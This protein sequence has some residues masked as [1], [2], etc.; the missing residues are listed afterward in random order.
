MKIT[1]Y[2]TV[3]VMLAG[4]YSQQAYAEKLVMLHTNDT[5]S[6][7]DPTDKNLGGVLRRKVLIDSVRAAQPNTLLID[8]GDAVQGT[9]FFNLYRGEVEHKVMNMLGYDIAI[10][11]NH[12][13][14]NGVDELAENLRHNHATWL[15]TNYDLDGSAL[16]GLFKPYTIKKFGDH[17]VG[18]IG[19]NLEPKG[20]ISEGNYDGVVY[21]DAIKAANATAWHLKHNEKADYVVAVTHIG[22]DSPVLPNDLELAAAS[23]DI[24]IIIGGHSHTVINPGSGA[25]LVTNAAGRPVL[26][27]QA[28]KSGA[29]MGEITL[30]LDDGETDYR[31]LSVDSR[32][33]SRT[34][35]ELDAILEPYRHGVDSLMNIKIGRSAGNYGNR[36]PELINFVSDFILDQGRRMTPDIDLAI[37][38]KGSLRRDMPKGDVTKGVIL[39]MQPFAN[40]IVTLEVKGSDL[41]E[42]FDVM[43]TRGGDGV[44]RGVDIAFD[45]ATGQCTD[46][47]I[48]GRPLDPDATY[49]VATIDY[50]A[51]GGDY[52]EPLT[53]GNRLSE[54]K[55]VVHDD[56]IDYIVSLKN[57]KINPSSTL[58]MHPAR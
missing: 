50:L 24:D 25:E 2:A 48:N 26:V 44:S 57:K 31:L 51:N 37:M 35:R 32:L 38:N 22:Y 52:M 55:G 53:R 16:D 3:A 43:A 11:G 33:D 17:T 54:S 20:M 41:K 8:A 58:R 1:R 5:H 40:R 14:D 7:I 47:T 10:L 56:L 15:T 39:M 4:M 23:E 29:L 30:D 45:P 12:D 42:A 19:I 6:Q 27:V 46:I 36:S 49:R 18:F 9:M 21:L 28:G 13:F 34:D